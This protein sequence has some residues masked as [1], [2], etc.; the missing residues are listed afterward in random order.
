[1][2]RI[3]T[4]SAADYEKEELINK[5][6]ICLPM[7]I[8]FGE[9]EY[10]QNVNISKKEFFERL[11]DSEVFPKTSQPTPFEV[12]DVFKKLKDMGD[13]CV[14]ITISSGLSGTYQSV[15]LL[16]ETA[17]I[18][19]AYIVDSRNATAGERILVDVAVKMRDEG[20]SAKEIYEKLEVL[21]HK[22]A[23]LGCVDTL[24]YLYKGGR[25]SKTAYTVGTMA[26]VKPVITVT[27]EG[28]VEVCHKVLSMRRGIKYMVESMEKNPP[29]TDYPIYAVYS[30]DSK[31]GE[32]LKKKIEETGYK[33]GEDRFFE[34]GPVIGAH[35][36]R[37]ACGVIYIEK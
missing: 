27:D 16:K 11:A 9:K 20:K 31:N 29:D 10:R 19:N 14:V 8:L 33:I 17:E 6:I 21:K 12:E 26:N 13:E 30:Y 1:V 18:E 24:E 35:V 7:T 32:I 4:D 28:K 3:I 5:D 37:G 36:G 23:L 34:I 22:V 15:C 2:V 25:L